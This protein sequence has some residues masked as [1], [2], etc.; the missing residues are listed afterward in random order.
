VS[1]TPAPP[2]RLYRVDIDAAELDGVVRHG[3]MIASRALC[4]A[5]SKTGFR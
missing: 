3:R 5:M 4:L 1:A 2:E